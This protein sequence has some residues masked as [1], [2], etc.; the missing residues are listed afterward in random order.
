MFF[1]SGMISVF[2]FV[3]RHT[4]DWLLLILTLRFT[5]KVTISLIN[6]QIKPTYIG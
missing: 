5:G 6:N 3:Q 2:L 4:T 1:F